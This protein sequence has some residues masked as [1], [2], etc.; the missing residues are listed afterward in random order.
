MTLTFDSKGTRTPSYSS[1]L[2]HLQADA[3]ALAA[4]QKK[5]GVFWRGVSMWLG[6]PAALLAA[7]AGVTGLV[8]SDKLSVLLAFAAAAISG[9]LALTTPDKRAKQTDALENDCDIF[10]TRVETERVH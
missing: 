6:I 1:I 10:A 5:G 3:E 9:I 4:S 7:A 2:E 8:N